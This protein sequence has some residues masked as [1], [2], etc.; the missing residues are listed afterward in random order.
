MADEQRGCD[1]CRKYVR[2]CGR[3]TIEGIC[4]GK[5]NMIETKD[6]GLMIKSGKTTDCADWKGWPVSMKAKPCPQCGGKRIWRCSSSGFVKI[7]KI[8]KLREYQYECASCHFRSGRAY[9][10]GG[11]LLK[12][13]MARYTPKH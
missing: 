10:K 3:D 1:T 2:E 13:Q 7:R 5:A 11:A 4:F 8:I 12:W 9:T 6:G